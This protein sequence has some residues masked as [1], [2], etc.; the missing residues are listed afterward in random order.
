M[1]D[2]LKTIIYYAIFLV[3]VIVVATMLWGGTK[4]E[5]TTA[6][7]YQYFYDEKIESFVIDTDNTMAF[8]LKGDTT[9]YEFV[10]RDLYLFNNDLGE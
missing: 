5:L 4:S 6:N 1:K 2:T 9:E 7:V 3:I 8:K 10:I